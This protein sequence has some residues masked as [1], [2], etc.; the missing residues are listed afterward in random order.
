MQR[1]VQ[2]LPPPGQRRV[3]RY[4][5]TG[6]QERQERPQEPL[7]LPEWQDRIGVTTGSAGGGR[8]CREI[9]RNRGARSE[10][11]LVGRLAPKR[12]MREHDVVFMDNS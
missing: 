9:G 5:E 2:T 11:H 3:I 4:F 8:A 6:A 1:D 7:G 12:R 10:V